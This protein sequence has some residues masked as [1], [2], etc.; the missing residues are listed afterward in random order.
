MQ[1][2]EPVDL[3]GIVPVLPTPFNSQGEIDVL[4]LRR[5][6]RFA[7]ARKVGGICTPAYG[8]EFYKLSDSERKSVIETVIAE[9]NGRVPVIACVGHPSTQVAVEM[10]RFAQRAGAAVL[11]VLVP[12]AVPLDS[13]AILKHIRSIGSSVELPLMLQ[14]ADFVGTGLPVPFLVRMREEVPNL[15]Y[16]KLES[17]LPGQ[18]YSELI[19]AT[20]GKLKI[21]CGWAGMHMLDALERG[22]CGVMPG[23]GLVDIYDLVYRA[24]KTGEL[25][26]SRSLFFKLL[27]SIVFSMQDIELLNLFEK[28][29]LK[30]RGII[31]A[32]DLREPTRGF[33]AQ[34][35]RE[36][37]EYC[38][39][40]LSLLK[41]CGLE[42][43]ALD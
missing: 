3:H 28:N 7:I 15:E 27:P 1:S 34:Y 23:C 4:E 42:T 22:A 40:S 12:R 9:A 18:R 25:P 32:A 37:Q 13:E 30:A 17:V 35:V 10:G 33:D 2:R 31:A 8:S 43:S 19:N 20:K 24:F 38:E 16:A 36:L 39:Y 11:C 21:L 14:D 5:V 26:K 29:L 41:E 6:V